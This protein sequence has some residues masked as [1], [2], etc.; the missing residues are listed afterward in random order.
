MEM[1]GEAMNPDKIF[2]A[3]TVL[4]ADHSGTVTYDEYEQ[5][6]L[7]YD[8]NKAFMTFDT[9]KQG[10]IDSSELGSLCADMGLQLS[11]AELKKAMVTLDKDS[12]GTISFDEFL[13]WWEHVRKSGEEM[14]F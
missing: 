11:K 4:D 9:D 12:D 6:F 13:P 2:Q 5:W 10:S 3:L 1:I 8:A 14:K 7:S